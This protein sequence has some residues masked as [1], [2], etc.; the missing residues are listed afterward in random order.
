VRFYFGTSHCIPLSR[1]LL[2]V[3]SLNFSG[4]ELLLHKQEIN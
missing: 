1:R 3:S 4:L 2:I